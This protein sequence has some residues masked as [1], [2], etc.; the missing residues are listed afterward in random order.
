MI[1][2]KLDEV[3]RLKGVKGRELAR[4]MEIGEN[5]LSR[6]RHEVP[7]RL[8][9]V[10]LDGL[11]RELGCS[12]AD[13]LEFRAE[14]PLAPAKKKARKSEPADDDFGSIVAEAL[15]AALLEEPRAPQTRWAHEAAPAHPRLHGTSASLPLAAPAH[16]GLPALTEKPTEIAAVAKPVGVTVVKGGALGARLGQLRRNRAT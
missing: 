11:C 7:D 5:Y 2:W 14:K 4:R 10:L 3:L 15:G 16:P 9:L 13:L 12:I 1:V 8:S 6:V